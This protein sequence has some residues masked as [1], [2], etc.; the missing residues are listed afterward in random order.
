MFLKTTSPKYPPTYIKKPN[1]TEAGVRFV[2]VRE[3][4]IQAA[5]IFGF[6]QSWIKRGRIHPYSFKNYL[7]AISTKHG[8]SELRVML[9]VL[10]LILFSTH[11][12]AYL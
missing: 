3:S 10:L 6:Y 7:D 1:Q 5:A 8:S 9:S 2:S 12:N 4:F 11:N